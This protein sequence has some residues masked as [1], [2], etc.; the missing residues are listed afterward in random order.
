MNL[1]GMEEN[2]KNNRQIVIGY[3]LG[4]QF[5]QIS[6]CYMDKQIPETYSVSTVDEHYNIPLCL[7]KRRDVNQWFF[8]WVAV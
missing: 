3:D 1:L 8:G 4:E 2:R 6:N 7:C 5:A